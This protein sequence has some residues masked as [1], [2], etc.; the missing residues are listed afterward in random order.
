MEKGA[1]A[2]EPEPRFYVL[3]PLWGTSKAKPA[4]ASYAGLIGQAILA[5]SDGRLSLAEIYAWI[6]TT[7]PFYER[8]ERGWQNSIRHNLSL[9]KSFYKI[10]R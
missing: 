5:S 6:N 1:I 3:P 9:N 7:F 10:D 4:S 8:G 2:E